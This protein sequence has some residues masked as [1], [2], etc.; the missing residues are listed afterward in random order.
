MMLP[1]IDVTIIA[2]IIIFV[3][4]LGYKFLIKQEEAKIIKERQKELNKQAKEEQKKGN[5]QK[6]NELLSEML[7]E[8]GKLMKMTMKPMLA[9]MLLVIFVLPWV[10]SNY[11]DIHAPLNATSIT[12]GDK[13]LPIDIR[14]DSILVDNIQYEYGKNV[15]FENT[16]WKI[17]K[18]DRI[19]FV[20]IITLLPV[21]LPYVNDDLGWLGWYFVV[22]LPVMIVM[23]KLMGIYI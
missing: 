9:S 1:I 12:V 8:N 13:Q 7:K 10:A 11:G 14:N 16:S 22:S 4:N 5:Q 20:K 19:E 21:S 15:M 23:R 17:Y 2:I 18:N 6:S 3:I